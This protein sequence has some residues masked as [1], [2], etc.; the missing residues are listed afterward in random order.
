MNELEQVRARLTPQELA[1]LETP[2]VRQLPPAEQLAYLRSNRRVGFLATAFA[3]G[4]RLLLLAGGTIAMI[5]YALAALFG[6]RP[7]G[8]LELTAAIGGT[9]ILTWTAWMT[10]ALARRLRTLRAPL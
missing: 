10:A 9:G 3:G 7:F 4:V 5:A 1:L 8:W 2:E 6:D